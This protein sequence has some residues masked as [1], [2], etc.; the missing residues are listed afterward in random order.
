ML[1]ATLTAIGIA[2]FAYRRI[3]NRRGEAISAAGLAEL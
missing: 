3:T 2:W 1:V